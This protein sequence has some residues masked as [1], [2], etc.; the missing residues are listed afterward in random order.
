MTWPPSRKPSPKPSGNWEKDR[1][2][3]RK[4]P[5]PKPNHAL[6][7]TDRPGAPQSTLV[8][9]LPV[10]PPTSPDAIPLGVTNALLGGSF[11]SRITAN[12]REQKGYTYS[13]YSEIARHYHTAYWAQHAD[14][15]TQFTGPSL[16]E[17]FGEIDRL[18]KEPPSALELKG[19]QSYLSGIFVIR[20]S[21]RQA[22]IGQLQFVDFQGLGEDYLKSYVPKVNSV[23]SPHAEACAQ[24][25]LRRAW[26]RN[27]FRVGDLFG[28]ERGV[29][30]QGL[31]EIEVENH[32]AALIAAVTDHVLPIFFVIVVLLLGPG[33]AGREIN[34]LGVARPGKSVDFVLA[35]GDGKGLAASG[36]NQKQLGDVFIFVFVIAV[37]SFAVSRVCVFGFAGFAFG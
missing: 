11:N 23:M 28:A 6:D 36:R 32:V 37:S 14:V 9:G 15:T 26:R 2:N 25:R 22:L 3:W 5:P 24:W 8:A 31:I 27:L 17:I 12:I 16:K 1:Q 33:L 34:C 30:R 7:P 19:I 29:T 18:Q 13:P 4:R 10:A 35:G 20:N 21:S